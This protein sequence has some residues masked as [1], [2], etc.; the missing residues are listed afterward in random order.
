[1]G[2]ESPSGG[3]IKSPRGLHLD[4][5]MHLRVGKRCQMQENMEPIKNPLNCRKKKEEKKKNSMS[6]I[7]RSDNRQQRT[8]IG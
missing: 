2:A 5:Y 6:L 7:R 4:R 3:R 1:M 8:L